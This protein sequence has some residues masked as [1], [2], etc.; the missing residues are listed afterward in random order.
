MHQ[1]FDRI[2]AEM[3]ALLL[4]RIAG[5]EPKSVTMPARLVVRASA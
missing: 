3:V 2:S 5:A 4:D 1:P